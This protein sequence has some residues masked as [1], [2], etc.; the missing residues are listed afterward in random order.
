MGSVNGKI[1]KC[2]R[3]DKEIFL[4]T[5][6]EGETDGG[7]TRWNKFEEPP[8]GWGYCTEVHGDLC[9]ECRA[10]LEKI[11]EDFRKTMHKYNWEIEGWQFREEY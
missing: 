10:K 8:E 5:T 4:K 9:P 2:D 11:L 1:L 7:Y 6:G 3:C